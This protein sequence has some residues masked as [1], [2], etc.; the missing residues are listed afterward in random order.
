MAGTPLYTAPEQVAINSLDIDTRADIYALGVL[1]YELLT[2]SPP[3]DRERLKAAA[4]DEVCRV[5]REEEPPRPSTRISTSL[6]LPSLAASRQTDPGKLSGLIKGDLDWI[7]LKSLEKERNRRYD[8]ATALVA[9]IERHLNDEPVMAAPPT[10]GYRA[11]K[12]VRKHRTAVLTVAAAAA[13]LTLGL[14]TTTWQWCRADANAKTATQ[15]EK[16]A[17]VQKIEADKQ[18]DAA[19]LEAYVAD[20]A[21]GQTAMENKNWPEARRRLDACAVSKRGFEWKFLSL[22]ARSVGK[23]LPRDF[24]DVVLSPDGRLGLSVSSSNSVQLRDMSGNLVGSPMKTCDIKDYC[25]VKPAFSPNGRLVVTDLGNGTRQLWN[26]AGKPVGVPIKTGNIDIDNKNGSIHFEAVCSPD[27]QHVLT[28]PDDHTVQLQ[29]VSGR[30]VG[31]AMKH[32][33]AV[34]SA[35]FSPDGR[36]VLTDSKDGTT[37]LWDALGRPVGKIMHEGGGVAVDIIRPGAAFSP[38]GNLLITTSY[39][40]HIVRIWDLTGQPVGEPMKHENSVTSVGFSPDNRIVVTEESRIVGRTV[41]ISDGTRKWLWDLNGKLL[42]QSH[43]PRYGFQSAGFSPDGRLRLTLADNGRAIQLRDAAGNPVGELMQNEDRVDQA[44]FSPDGRLVLTSSRD[45]GIVRLWNLN[46]RPVSE[47]IRCDDAYFSKSPFAPDGRRVI[48]VSNGQVCVWGVQGKLMGTAPREFSDYI[49]DPD[50]N[51]LILAECPEPDYYRSL[52]VVQIDRV[53][54]PIL[55][56]EF[57]ASLAQDEISALNAIA[58]RSSPVSTAFVPARTIRRGVNRNTIELV[59]PGVDPVILRHDQAVTAAAVAPDCLRAVTSTGQLVRFWDAASGREIA[60]IPAKNDVRDLQFTP[61]G[62][63]LILS[64]E[65]EDGAVQIWDSRSFEE[66]QKDRDARFAEFK[67]ARQ[68]VDRLLMTTTP[69]DRLADAIRKDESL[70]AIRKVQALSWLSY[71]L[72]GIDARA[73]EV[74]D[75]IS[76]NAMN[77]GDLNENLATIKKLSQKGIFCR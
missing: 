29:E 31:E 18:R 51:T 21:L 13:L 44:F 58:H 39:D 56:F 42:Q 75:E 45:N 30:L 47:P 40:Q 68:Y 8:T 33:A 55:T 63:Q 2:G 22:K 11:R 66:R 60:Q 67:P 77:R 37:R 16:I 59:A 20:I 64:M 61:D 50:G 4:W 34:N 6:L 35:V 19:E 3:L 53:D 69:D 26:L 54:S 41:Y 52:R 15:N 49:A 38:N 48:T 70:R 1:L 76:E 46:G 24:V 23:E 74:F 25:A 14:A 7:I 72:K 28:V 5:I 32:T 43:E 27:G 62:T 17:E 73:K 36:F 10:V 71:G 57:D 9:D 12:F 65:D